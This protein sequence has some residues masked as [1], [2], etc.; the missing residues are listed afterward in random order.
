MQKLEI[1]LVGLLSLAIFFIVLL[2][3]VAA[4]LSSDDYLVGVASF[5]ATPASANPPISLSASGE[6]MH[7]VL[8]YVKGAPFL[9]S[10]AVFRPEEV[11]H[12]KD[13][14]RRIGICYF[15]LYLLLALALL[16]LLAL[17]AV[18]GKRRNFHMLVG[19]S[20]IASG[21][22]LLLFSVS[23]FLLMSDFSPLFDTFHKL[24]F[25][26]SGWQFPSSYALV[27]L[28]TESFFGKMASELFTGII[29]SG[30][31]LLV[32]SRL[33]ARWHRIIGKG[34]RGG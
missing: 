11:S 26:A 3:N 2:G 9:S 14:R 23:A 18:S 31:A 33:A 21:I 19:R 13:V 20:L 16:L 6:I 24:L 29:A 30:I 27:N 15:S 32:A 25:G 22:F 12:L 17:F 7:D 4:L 8:S 5:F 34:V 1:A 10:A 28:F